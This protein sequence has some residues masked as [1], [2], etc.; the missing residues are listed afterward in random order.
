MEV[1]MKSF[2]I[3]LTVIFAFAAVPLALEAATGT[4]T[5]IGKKQTS[6]KYMKGKTSVQKKQVNPSDNTTATD[7]R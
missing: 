7:T 1:Q 3:A 6:E 5:G 2:I 4:N